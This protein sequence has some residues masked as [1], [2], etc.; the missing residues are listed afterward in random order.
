M[1]V[2]WCIIVLISCL[3]GRL[4][5]QSTTPLPF[6]ELSVQSPNQT[7]DGT[8]RPQPRDTTAHDGDD[9]G[10]L[11][12]GL[13]VG[14]PSGLAV[15]GGFSIGDL[16]LRISGGAWG[17]DWTGIQGDVCYNVIHSAALAMGISFIGGQFRTK[18]AVGQQGNAFELQRYYGIACDT[19][20]SGFYLQTGLAAGPGR[21]ASPQ[22]S[23]QFGYLWGF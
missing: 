17:R 19:Y 22:F 2:F 3:S 15:A 14:A 10:R 16:A 20:L 13:T 11:L 23:Y 4:V 1:K 18:A 12:I 6:Q 21:Y 7:S 8:S 9:S 5:A